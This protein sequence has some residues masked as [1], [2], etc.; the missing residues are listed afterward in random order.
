MEGHQLWT[1]LRLSPV[2]STPKPWQE[3]SKQQHSAELQA[4]RD[5]RWQ[6]S[7]RSCLRS[8]GGVSSARA[9]ESQGTHWF[10]AWLQFTRASPQGREWSLVLVDRRGEACY[11]FKV[12]D[13]AYIPYCSR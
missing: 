7:C 8:E 5:A 3:A 1:G 2:L 11:V 10:V 9:G 12:A 4:S 13:G 6:T